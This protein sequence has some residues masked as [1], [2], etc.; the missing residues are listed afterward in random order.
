LPDDAVPA[1]DAGRYYSFDW[2]NAHVVSLDSNDSLFDAAGGRC[3]MLEWLDRDLS[4][5]NKFW[6]IVVLHHPAYSAGIHSE[7]EESVLVRRF[8]VPILEKHHVPL[9]LN[10]HEHSYQRSFPIR[11][12]KVV[13][14][15]E[16]SIYV[17]TGGGGATLHPVSSSEL[18]KTAVSIHHF[19]SCEVNNGKLHLKATTVNGETLDK[20]TVAPFPVLSDRSVVN[21]A[22]YS[23]R[24]AP[25]S[26]VSIFGLQLA[27]EDAS[28]T[29]LPLPKALGGTSVTLND[30]PIP[31]LM[32]SARQ[33]NVQIPYGVRGPCE[34]VIRNGNGSAKLPVDVAATAPALFAN[35]VFH[36]DDSAVGPESPATASEVLTLYATGIGTP[37][38]ESPILVKFA[39]N[40]PVAATASLVK[41][42]PGLYAIRFR[43]SGELASAAALQVIAGAAA[44]NVLTVPCSPSA[45][46]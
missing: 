43:V 31:I 10:G 41:S 19:V 17:T 25:G 7:E 28:W 35:A 33:L 34:L 20:F 2:G 15:S 37:E 21:A 5:T 40:A 42:V 18:I 12:A 38:D 3:K 29:K 27:S 9:V 11:G 22:D 4:E 39:R 36:A 8:I 32:S 24:I 23:E 1:V 6:R 14:E 13:A 45:R 30:E 44:S 26:L 16:G 46:H